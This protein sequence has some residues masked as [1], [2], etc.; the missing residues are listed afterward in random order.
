MNLSQSRLI[1][2]GSRRVM[3]QLAQ[4]TEGTA[5]RTLHPGDIVAIHEDFPHGGRRWHAA[6]GLVKAVRG[7]RAVVEWDLDG[8]PRVVNVGNLRKV[9]EARQA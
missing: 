7:G 8:L 4:S 3:A 9:G 2:S 6:M 1:G 5:M